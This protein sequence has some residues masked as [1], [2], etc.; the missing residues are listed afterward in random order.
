MFTVNFGVR[1]RSVIFP[2]LFNVYTDDLICLSDANLIVFIIVYADDI[3]LLSP[4]VTTLQN[5]FSQR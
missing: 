5:L 3:L 1:Q 2:L 4:S